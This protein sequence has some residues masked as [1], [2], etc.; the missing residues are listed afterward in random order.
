MKNNKLYLIF[1]ILIIIFIFGAAA[2]CN[3]CGILSA[4]VII[5][6][7]ETEITASGENNIT[8][9]ESDTTH[10][11]EKTEQG[12][13]NEGGADKKPIV[14]IER[15][16]GPA[17]EGDLCVQ[18]YKANITGSPKPDIKWNHDDSK[19]AFG[20][21]V[22]QVNLKSGEEFDLKATVTNTAGS[23]TEAIHV[24]YELPT[25]PSEP[26]QQISFTFDPKSGPE[27]TEVVL[28]LSEPIDSPVEVYYNGKKI[29]WL[30][31]TKTASADGKTLKEI[32]PAGESSG[33]FEL[34]YDGK[35]VKAAEQFMV[36]APL[37]ADLAITNISSYSST[38]G[39]TILVEIKNIGTADLNNAGINVVCQTV[40][41]SIADNTSKLPVV[42]NETIYVTIKAG[43]EDYFFPYLI[44]DFSLYVYPAVGCT[45]TLDGDPT[46]NNNEFF[47]SIP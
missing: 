30:V 28:K 17:Q 43:G 7:A 23:D 26:V 16:Y 3:Q 11:Q 40:G 9:T 44:L 37:Q 39:D 5:T 31:F 12:T 25:Q 19:G 27:G 21:D 24:K 34:K 10:A 45:I 22:A 8:E 33:Y 13:A 1:S 29:H 41:I 35:S 38:A 4:P 18:R 42:S 46:P 6:T 47:I 20:R 32:I 15:I 36:T 2:T 14:S